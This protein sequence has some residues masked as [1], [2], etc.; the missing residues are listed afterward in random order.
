MLSLYFDSIYRVLHLYLMN[1]F[2]PLKRLLQSY[3]NVTKFNPAQA[4]GAY[5][6]NAWIIQIVDEKRRE[7]LLDFLK[8]SPLRFDSHMY[9]F[10]NPIKGTV[11]Y[12]RV[13]L[14]TNYFNYQLRSL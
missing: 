4:K 7:D 10:F 8:E 2:E 9:E 13:R 5:G 11:Y 1:H 3:K 12:G 14:E 6:L